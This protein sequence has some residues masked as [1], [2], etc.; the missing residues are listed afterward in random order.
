MS[1]R[2]IVVF[3]TA[4]H[5]APAAPSTAARF[6]S[7]CSAC[8]TTSPATTCIVAGSSAICPAVYRTP[9]ATTACE[10]GP[11]AAGACSV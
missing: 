9:L 3:T 10:Y 8:A 7:T 5:D 2:K 4:D 1:A 6:V 11:I